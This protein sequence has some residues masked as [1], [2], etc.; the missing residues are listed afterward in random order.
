MQDNINNESIENSAC[1]DH[2][3]L[4]EFLSSQG[5]DDYCHS[6]IKAQCALITNACQCVLFLADAKTG[7]F[8]PVSKWPD[9]G[10]DPERLSEI[11]ERVIAE[12]CGLLLELTPSG[13]VQGSTG[14]SYGLGYPFFIDGKLQG[15]IALEALADNQ[16]QLATAMAQLQWGSGWLELLFRRRQTQE[17]ERLLKNL[18]AAVDLMALVL[19]ETSFKGAAMAFVTQLAL[20]LECER[21]SLA[22]IKN[23]HSHIQA[24]S[25]SAQIEQRMNLNRAIE[26]AMDESIIQRKEILY[27]VPP[28]R[29]MIIVRNHEQLARQYGAGCILTIPFYGEGKYYGALTIERPDNRQFSDDEIE[30]SHSIGALIFPVLESKRRN[31]RNL[32]FKAFDSLKT[33][34][35]RFIGEGYA[36]RKA[37]L[38]L[39]LILVGFFSFKMWDYRVSGNTTLEGKVRRSI[40]APLEGYV[41]EAFVRAGDTVEEGAVMCTLDDR[42]LRLERLNLISKQN[43][44]QK[45][46][47]ESVAGHKRAD[48]EI[49]KAQLDQAAAQLELV[50]SEL[51]RTRI[52]APFKGIVL[53]GDLSQRL[54][55]STEKGEVL[56]EI[57]PLESYR[58][59]LEID[60]RHIADVKPGQQ[61]RVIL[62]SLS[63]EGFGF[64][65]EKITPISNAKEGKNYFRVEAA[66]KDASERLRPGMTGVGKIYVGRRKLIDVLTGDLRDWVRLK[67]WSWR[68]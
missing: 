52:T 34:S 35:S 30:M 20:V 10:Q 45:Q 13:D 62:S 8:S 39:V 19:S 37:L 51:K 6:W 7:A 54:G 12:K 38:I 3:L 24:V 65:V 26:L 43:Q 16:G 59:I 2:N 5:Y 50:E 42:D 47:Q 36:G 56:F 11:A 9:S 61:G 23:N 64:V 4:N 28:D 60:E 58:I 55:G 49:I 25:H 22:F 18:R 68:P 46:Y 33:Q 57:A 17:G 48:S 1:L 14:L 21:V 29:G 40:V 67:V 53:S 63:D 32:V 27:P 31:D 44:Y 15:L 41:N 66:L